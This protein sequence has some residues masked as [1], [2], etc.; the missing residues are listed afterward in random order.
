VVCA[1]TTLFEQ[2]PGTGEYDEWACTVCGAAITTGDSPLFVEQAD[3]AA[4]VKV[5]RAA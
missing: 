1:R 4:H 3:R 5:H 2:P